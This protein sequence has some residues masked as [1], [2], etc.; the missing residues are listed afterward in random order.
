MTTDLRTAGA[1]TTTMLNQCPTVT[2]DGLEGTLVG[3]LPCGDKVQL[4]LIVGGLRAW[5]T[6]DAGTMIAVHR[7]EKP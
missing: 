3:I 6:I 1:I 2:V 4:A 5:K 7:E